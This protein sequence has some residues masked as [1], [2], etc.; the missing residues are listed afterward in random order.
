MVSLRRI[1]PSR[2]SL[3]G[4]DD[5]RLVRLNLDQVTDMVRSQLSESLALH[6]ELFSC[7][8]YDS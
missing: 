4:L 8:C 5:L 6:S 7:G 1:H 2:L 3:G